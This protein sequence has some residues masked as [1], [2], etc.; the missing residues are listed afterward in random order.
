[1]KSV[2][3]VVAC[4]AFVSTNVFAVD[5]FPAGPNCKQLSDW[6]GNM[7]GCAQQRAAVFI[8][9]NPGLV[10]RTS[11]G[12][13]VALD[14][15]RK[16]SIRRECA[17]CLD[18]IALR[19]QSRLLLVREQFSEGNTWWLFSLKTGRGVETEGWPLFS[20]NGR[21]LFAFSDLDE[22]GY[23][24]P[25]ARIYDIAGDEPKL[26]WRGLT[27]SKRKEGGSVQAWGPIRPKWHSDEKLTFDVE[28]WR[29][30]ATGGG[31]VTTGSY[32]L[33]FVDD[34]WLAARY[35]K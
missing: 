14:N 19:A 12:L 16:K 9:G 1:M 18:P 7:H 34:Q 2:V 23:T 11:G 35:A 8:R 28:E 17:S 27:I 25:I 6:D 4:A 21:F 5:Q 29:S 10:Q 15:G 26:L 20:P 22:S 3:L 32:V 31:P 13:R 24:R 33:R 30:S